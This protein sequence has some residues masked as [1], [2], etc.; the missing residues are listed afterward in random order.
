V[1]PAERR[2]EDAGKPWLSDVAQEVF[3]GAHVVVDVPPGGETYSLTFL[4]AADESMAV[5]GRMEF[6]S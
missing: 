1:F 5:R 4:S 3:E 6:K 2:R